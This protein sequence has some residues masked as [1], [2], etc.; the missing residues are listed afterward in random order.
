ATPCNPLQLPAILCNS[1]QFPVIPR[2]SLPISP[3][4]CKAPFVPARR[5]IFVSTKRKGENSP[6]RSHPRRSGNN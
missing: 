3:N 5:R 1:L 6:R 4:P 2:N